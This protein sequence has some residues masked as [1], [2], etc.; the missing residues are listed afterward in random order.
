MQGPGLIH[1][2]GGGAGGSPVLDIVAELPLLKLQIFFFLNHKQRSK[3]KFVSLD[4][5]CPSPSL[6]PTY[7]LY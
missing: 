6:L 1:F 3:L 5:F 4:L 2:R 7:P